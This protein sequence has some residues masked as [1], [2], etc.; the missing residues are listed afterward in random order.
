MAEGKQPFL[1]LIAG[2]VILIVMIWIANNWIQKQIS[3]S[4][5]TINASAPAS[6]PAQ[7]SVATQPMD[8][9][10]AEAPVIDQSIS[11]QQGEIQ[12]KAQNVS[13][14]QIIYEKPLDDVLLV[15]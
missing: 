5:K 12:P 11:Q 8:N 15:Q 1:G 9:A 2:M 10:K 13:A 14:G 6:A 4:E 7:V 3:T